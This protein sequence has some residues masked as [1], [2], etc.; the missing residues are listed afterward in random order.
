MF[1]VCRVLSEHIRKLSRYIT[2]NHKDLLI[3]KVFQYECP[4]LSAQEA[5]GV[6]SAYKTPHDKVRCVLRCASCIMDLLSMSND[7][8]VPTADDFTPVLVYVI[9][10]VRI[11]NYHRTDSSYYYF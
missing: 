9:I 3:A 4:W 2:P 5:L 1:F 8:G 6:M 7:S 11:I 10:N